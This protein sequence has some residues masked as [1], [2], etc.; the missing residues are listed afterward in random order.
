[1]STR[2]YSD[3]NYRK[4]IYRGDNDPY[5]ASVSLLLHCDGAN[6]STT[7]TDSSSFNKTVTVNGGAQI[8]TAQ[9]KFG[10][11]SGYFD[12]TGDFLNLATSSDFSFGTGSFTVEM[13]AYPTSFS[14][15]FCLYDALVLS[16]VGTRS[17]SFVLVQNATTGYLRIFRNGSYS[18]TSSSGL[19]LNTWNHVEIDVS[20]GSMYFFVNGINVL[21]SAFSINVTSGGCV[22]GRYA[23]GGSNYFTGYL[24]DIRVTKGVA[25]HT[26]N[27]TPPTAP[28]PNR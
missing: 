7:F 24:D 26:A 6:G 28:S 16:G 8:S 27:F 2:F 17:N 10:G 3:D 9:S 21:T 20:G 18:S 12:G 11:A 1:M 19:T 4:K 14:A 22:I 15:E 13:W 5:Y 25:R 23:D